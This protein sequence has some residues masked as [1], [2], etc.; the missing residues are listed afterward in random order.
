MNSLGRI[1]NAVLNLSRLNG[2]FVKLDSFIK[3]VHTVLLAAD[4]GEE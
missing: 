3:I 1:A 2:R 4:L